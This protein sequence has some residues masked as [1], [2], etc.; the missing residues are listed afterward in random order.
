VEIEI[1]EGMGCSRW[2]GRGGKKFNN[3]FFLLKFGFR[4]LCADKEK[5]G[6]GKVRMGMGVGVMRGRMYV[7]G[8]RRVGSEV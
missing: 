3:L 4:D 8:D 1:A 5:E 6:R 7:E 2:G